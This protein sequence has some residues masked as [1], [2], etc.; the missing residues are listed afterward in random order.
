MGRIRFYGNTFNGNGPVFAMAEN[1]YSVYQKFFSGRTMSFT[2]PDCSDEFQFLQTCNN[3]K[4]SDL[5]EFGGVQWPI[6]QGTVYIEFCSDTVC[7]NSN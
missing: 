1:L 7:F 5:G 4:T 6:I 3:I 2:D